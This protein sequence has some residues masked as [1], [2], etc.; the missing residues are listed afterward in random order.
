ML[1]EGGACLAG[2]ML[3]QGYVDCIQAY[4]GNVLVGDGRG[5]L[6]RSLAATIAPTLAH[7][8][9]WRRRSVVGLG[10]DV[11]VEYQRL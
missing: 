9:R 10:D 7:A 8:P 1:V 11:L 4:V 5:V 6:D 2:S 3:E